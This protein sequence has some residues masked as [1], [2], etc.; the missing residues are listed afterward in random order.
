M[1]KKRHII[2]I[3]GGSGSGKTQIVSALLK[4]FDPGVVAFIS[5]DNYYLNRDSQP[6][7]E[8]GI[9]NFDTL[10]SIDFNSMSSDIDK[11]IKGVSIKQKLYTFNNPIVPESWMEVHP[12]PIIILEGLFVLSKTEILSKIDYKVFIDVP[13][14]Q[15]LRR[16]I[17]RDNIERGYDISDVLYR[18]DNHVT[19]AHNN[20]IEPC[21]SIADLIIYNSTSIEKSV[22]QLFN[23]IK[24]RIDF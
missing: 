9:K 8:N 14:M 10:N 22:E 17:K 6:V 19:P 4:K 12:A 20:F 24:M 23:A 2:G 11:M 3:T 16:R 1:N 18:F 13:E 21:K 7:D 15:R 5:Q